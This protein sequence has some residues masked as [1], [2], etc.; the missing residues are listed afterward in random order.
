VRLNEAFCLCVGCVWQSFEFGVLMLQ[1]YQG[2][3]TCLPLFFWRRPSLV[4]SKA[5]FCG[6]PKLL[7]ILLLCCGMSLGVI[8]EWKRCFMIWFWKCEV[9]WDHLILGFHG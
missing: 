1:E 2:Q 7:R 6:S 8:F 5:S 3:E 4:A 9:P